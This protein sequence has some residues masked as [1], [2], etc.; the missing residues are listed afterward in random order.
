MAR[1]LCWQSRSAGKVPK[2]SLRV[3]TSFRTGT[4]SSGIG[5]SKA[6]GF[7]ARTLRR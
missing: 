4:K 5:S 7:R 3:C 1:D 2:S 6:L